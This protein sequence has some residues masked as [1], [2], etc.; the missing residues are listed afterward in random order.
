MVSDPNGLTPPI[1][2]VAPMIT[3][4]LYS[5]P[6]LL[7]TL[8]A[9]FWAGHTVAARLAVGEIPPFMLTT[10][11]WVAVAAVLWPFYGAEIRKAWPQIRPRL[12][13]IVW[14]AVAGMTGFNALYYF[15]AHYTTAINIGI[16][17][18]SMPIFVLAGAWLAHGARASLVQWVG[19]LITALGVVVVATRGTPLSIL[20]VDLNTGD[21]AMVAACAVYAAYTVALRD[22]PDMPATAFFALLALIAAVT[23]L[24]LVAL[25]VYVGGLRLPTANGLLIT[26]WIAIFPSFLAQIFYL[27]GVDLIGPGRAGVFVNLVPV[28]AAAMAVVLIDE[29]FAA[30]HAVALVLVI[31]GIW[32]AQRTR[33]RG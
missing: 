33:G 27:R 18:G 20:E 28:F 15:A 10:L 13:G 14:L 21:L 24:P 6:G 3:K 4:R 32:L 17:Q 12:G 26:A 5:W 9:V 30:F 31:G 8:T 16:L 2:D 7:L 29:P 19:V 22:R 25:E 23:S 11:R 1:L